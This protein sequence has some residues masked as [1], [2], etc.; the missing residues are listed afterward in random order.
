MSTVF[1]KIIS[2]CREIYRMVK[3]SWVEGEVTNTFTDE[4]SEWIKVKY[5]GVASDATE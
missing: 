3:K 4:T 5:G 1:N 2:D